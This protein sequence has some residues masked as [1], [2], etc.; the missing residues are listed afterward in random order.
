MANNFFLALNTGLLT[1]GVSLAGLSASRLLFII[2]SIAITIFGFFFAI[3]WARVL[4]SYRE[5][6]TGKYQVIHE[7]EA[8][9]PRAPYDEEWG[10]L[11]RG[12]DEKLYKPLTEVESWV[13]NLFMFGY[14]AAEVPL[15]IWYAVEATG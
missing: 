6:N 9:L 10:K 8:L 13:P 4:K 14:W 3:A 11:G 7:L 1:V 5:L 12:Q 15:V 2:A